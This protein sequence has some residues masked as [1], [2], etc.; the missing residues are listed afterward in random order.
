MTPSLPNLACFDVE[1]GMLLLFLLVFAFDFSLA[2]ASLRAC[3]SGIGFALVIFLSRLFTAA[4][5]FGKTAR[6]SGRLPGEVNSPV[7]FPAR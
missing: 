2:L 5:S 7:G 1:L 3:P 6:R 4:N